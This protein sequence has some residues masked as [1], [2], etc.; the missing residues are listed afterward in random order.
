MDKIAAYEE[1]LATHPLWEK[2]AAMERLGIRELAS[3]AK[4]VQSTRLSDPPKGMIG[5]D[6][7][8]AVRALLGDTDL[9][10]LI[11]EVHATNRS[12]LS[13][14][15]KKAEARYV[16]GSDD[17]SKQGISQRE[18][19]WAGKTGRYSGLPNSV[20]SRL[21]NRNSLRG[22]PPIV[23]DQ[24][25]DEI[26][27]ANVP[28]IGLEDFSAGGVKLH[29]DREHHTLFRWGVPAKNTK[30]QLPKWFRGSS[31]AKEAEVK[32]I[33]IPNMTDQ[34]VRKTHDDLMR[35][36]EDS[37]RKA[38]AAKPG[39]FIQKWRQSQYNSLMADAKSFHA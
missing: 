13:E 22:A 12:P 34:E 19:E 36:A 39:S 26:K 29:Y 20:F 4:K 38:E 37:K 23:H 11:R 14:T 35:M 24:T 15:V 30:I 17:W 33:S 18:K 16:S 32:L 31:W 5:G 10:S 25:V 9:D 8:S 1:I 21:S 2:S 28:G 7:A 27:D 6:S 3:G